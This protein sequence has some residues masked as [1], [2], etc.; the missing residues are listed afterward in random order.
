MHNQQLQQLARQR[1]QP[2][3]GG[4]DVPRGLGALGFVHILVAQHLGVADQRGHRGFEFVR[5]AAEKALLPLDRLLQCL[6]VVF[7]RRSHAVE[8][9]CNLSDLVL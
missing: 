9:G 7:E 1:F 5:K 4:K 2:F 3:R 6:D 8:V